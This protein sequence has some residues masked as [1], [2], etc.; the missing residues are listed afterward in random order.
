MVWQDLTCF[1]TFRY[2][3]SSLHPGAAICTHIERIYDVI[4]TNYFY[5]TLKKDSIFGA[6]KDVEKKIAG[7]VPYRGG[8]VYIVRHL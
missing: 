5:T 7:I 1:T 8:S 6:C 2:D 3:T 4:T